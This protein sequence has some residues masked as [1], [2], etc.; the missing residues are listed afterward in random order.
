ML[1]YKCGGTGEYLG[2]G[3][4]ITNCNV[5]DNEPRKKK[6]VSNA[7]INRKSRSYQEAIKDIMAINPD[8]SREEAVKMFDK[9]YNK[10]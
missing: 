10:D 1:C 2:N 7:P 6:S 5:C 4:I 3:M 9:A 8:I